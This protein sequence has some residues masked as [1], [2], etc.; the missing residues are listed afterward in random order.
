MKHDV[1]ELL[2]YY[3]NGTLDGADRARVEAELASCPSCA[4]ELRELERLGVALQARAEAQPPV[5]P[6]VLDRAL[7]RIATPPSAVVATRLRTAWWGAPAR[8]AT[9]AVLV[10]GFSAAAFAAYHAREA[11][12]S[13][14]SATAG[15][16]QAGGTSYVYRILPSEGKDASRAMQSQAQRYEQSAGAPA[17]APQTVAKQHRLAKTARIDILVGGVEAALVRVREMTRDDGGELTSLDDTSPRSAGAVHG[18]RLTVEV[19]AA[20]LDEMLDRL[21]ALGTV[22]NRAIDAE[23]VDAAIVDEEARLRNMRSEENDLRALMSR[24][25]KVDDILT[26]QQNLSEVRGQIEELDATHQ[27]DLHR[28]AT[29]T[30]R[31]SLTEER[32]NV[33]PAQPGPSARIDG[34]WQSGVNALAQTV[35]ALIST[36]AWCVA[37]S[38]VVVVPGAL[39]YAGA[40]LWRRRIASA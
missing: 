35:V 39:F 24:G 32:A 14:V 4:D 15:D 29:S 1:A 30:I 12:V 19:P 33:T 17:G 13:S 23:D 3:A 5:P 8:Y 22:Q 40:R 34:A 9:A 6:A 21:A 28:V 16:G 10:V 20:R 37:Y 7:A 36:I 38:P 26:V 25:G 11:E 18:A 27:H 2:P 31:I